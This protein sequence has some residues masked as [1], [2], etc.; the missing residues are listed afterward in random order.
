[1]TLALREV[2]LQALP[3]DAH[4]TILVIDG[5]AT[6]RES[7]AADLSIEGFDVVTAADGTEGLA[8]VG[9]VHPSLIL[10]DMFLS[11][12]S[13]LAVFRQIAAISPVPVIMVTAKDDEIDAVLALEAGAADHVTKPFRQRELTARVRAVLRRVGQQPVPV[14]A[15]AG[16]YA[17]G[18]VRVDVALRETVVRGVP[19]DLSRKEFD[20]LALLLSES[21]HVI[22]RDQCMERLWSEHRLG[23]S[24]TLDTHIKRLRKKIELDP[25]HPEHIITVRGIGY[26]FRS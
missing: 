18:P 19:V 26:R 24:R 6:A 25:A 8:A 7:L 11:D 4:P 20:L 14:A 23:D 9:T 16:A 22:T 21:G 1:M 17:I 2:E 3:P 5:D 13:G 10:L 15:P 12:Q